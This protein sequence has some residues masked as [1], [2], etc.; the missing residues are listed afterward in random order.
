MTDLIPDGITR[1]HVEAAIRDFDQGKAHKFGESTGYDLFLN[2]NRYPPKAIVG[3]AAAYVLGEPLGPYDF[4]G[5]LE[6][7]CFNLLADL[8]FQIV[9]KGSTDEPT[10]WLLIALPAE[11]RQHAGN[12]GYD[13]EVERTYRWD[14]NVPNCK[15]IRAGDLAVLR[16][17]KLLGIARFEEV[18]QKSGTKEMR[19]C[20]DCKRTTIK[21][22]ANL[23]PPY[24]CHKCQHE[25]DEPVTDIVPATLYAG[26]NHPGFAGD[27]IP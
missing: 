3:L 20:P 7:K 2:G 15:K 11:E 23:E 14:S 16:S 6:S 24:R 17:D 22:R 4:K 5:G 12:V 18:S 1:E 10:A 9:P 19:R 13:D 21:R 27:S 25:F 8:G 26:L